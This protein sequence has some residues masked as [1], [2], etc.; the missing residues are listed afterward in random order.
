MCCYIYH[1]KLELAL[2]GA[3]P[4]VQRGDAGESHKEVF[5]RVEDESVLSQVRDHMTQLAS[6]AV[7][8]L[9]SHD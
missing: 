7:P 6:R 4:R 5:W 9:I 1:N 3:G 2:V 8:G